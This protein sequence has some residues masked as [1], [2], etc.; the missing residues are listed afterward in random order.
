MHPM[1]VRLADVRG[2]RPSLS[3]LAHVGEIPTR[4]PKS[5][6]NPAGIHETVPSSPCLT[7]IYL[8]CWKDLRRLVRGGMPAVGRTRPHAGCPRD[9]DG[10]A[11]AWMEQ[12]MS[13]GL[14]A[15]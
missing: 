14:T 13:N 11:G 5:P 7:V 6:T 15:S 4:L 9:V 1:A 12:Q 10:A 8:L 2:C 3:G